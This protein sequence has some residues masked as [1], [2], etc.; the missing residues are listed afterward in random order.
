MLASEAAQQIAVAFAGGEESE[1]QGR[2]ITWT[3]TKPASE[4][5]PLAAILDSIA[6]GVMARVH[7]P[8]GAAT[9]I[10]AYV[11]FCYV[12]EHWP[13]R[14]LLAI[15]SP[16][17][18]CGKTTLLDLLGMLIPRAYETGGIT[19]AALFRMIAAYRPILL[20]DECDQWLKGAGAK[21]EKAGDLIACINAGWRMG[22]EVARCVGD[23]HEPRGFPV[24]TPKIL[25]G[26]G[27]F[28]DTIADRAIILTLE[29]KPADMRLVSVRADR[30][31]GADIRAQLSRWA[32]DHGDTFAAA[33]PDT[34]QW[35]NRAG[36]NWRP[37]FAV[38]GPGGRHLARTHP[39]RGRGRD[40]PG[41]RANRERRSQ[42][43]AP[44]GLPH[45]LR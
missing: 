14:P 41:C 25:A 39:G 21:S 28:P 20:L 1:Q 31:V 27:D 18:Q 3:E 32:A 10:A 29:R 33:D 30:P 2:R 26:I 45:R 35:T 22:G 9:V 5:K 40:G 6:S 17:K 7:L 16:V 24:D 12:F 34:G 4:S 37:L 43:D 8:D 44:H 36:D 15:S 38:G 23:E 42:D 11:A 19:A 13:I